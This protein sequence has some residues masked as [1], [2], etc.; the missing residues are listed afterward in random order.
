MAQ[1]TIT[2]IITGIF[3][4]ETRG[5][6][7]FYSIEVTEQNT[8]Y[9]QV[10]R[11]QVPQSNY[12]KINS[13]VKINQII[14]LKCNLNGRNHTGTDGITRN[15]VGVNAYDVVTQPVQ[16][17]PTPTVQPVQPVQQTASVPVHATPQPVHTPQSQPVQQAQATSIPAT[18]PMPATSPFPTPTQNDN[19]KPPF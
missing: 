1:L 12:D 5:S 11:I 7:T 19:T 4:Q 10:Y 8:Q 18:G 17:A 9:P 3:E 6:Y 13:H 15:Y 16:N 14:S 2:G